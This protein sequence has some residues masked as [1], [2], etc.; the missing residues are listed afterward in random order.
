VIFIDENDMAELRCL[1]QEKDAEIADLKELVGEM[2]DWI[3]TET[4]GQTDPS[5]HHYKLVQRAKE[6]IGK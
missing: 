1:L 5:D 6:V 2:A 4:F 3:T